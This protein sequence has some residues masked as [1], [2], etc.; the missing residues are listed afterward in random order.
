[1]SIVFEH[2][3]DHATVTWPEQLTPEASAALVTAVDHLLGLYFYREVE[4]LIVASDG[5]HI[6]ALRHLHDAL[7]RWR[8]GEVRIRTRVITRAESA[9]ALMLSLGD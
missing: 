2:H 1:M 6:G 9:A 4:L 7:G 5:G 8:A 3:R